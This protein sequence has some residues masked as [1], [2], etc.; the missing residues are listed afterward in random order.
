MKSPTVDWWDKKQGY[1]GG[2]LGC[3]GAHH[4]SWQ[5]RGGWG[6][7]GRFASPK[8]L[9]GKRWLVRYLTPEMKVLLKLLMNSNYL[10]I[11]SYAQH[12]F[13]WKYPMELEN[14]N[15]EMKA[16]ARQSRSLMDE[17]SVHRGS[18]NQFCLC[19]L[20]RVGW[21]EMQHNAH[22]NVESTTDCRL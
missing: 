2:N 10:V 12:I 6:R 5:V 14:Q 18:C 11:N 8:A 22:L 7:L 20:L 19:S 3:L 9:R 13:L 17:K 1:V 16:N 15:I 4:Q 21:N